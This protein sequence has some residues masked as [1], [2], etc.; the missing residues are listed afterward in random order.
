MATARAPRRVTPAAAGTRRAVLLFA[1]ALAGVVLL[2]RTGLPHSS[3]SG[4]G[5]RVLV[6]DD[7]TAAQLYS[8][9]RDAGSAADFAAKLRS[10]GL[11]A[12]GGGGPSGGA[13]T[14][15]SLDSSAGTD[16]AL[17]AA[18][19]KDPKQ[20]AGGKVPQLSKELAHGYARDGIIIVTWA[21]LH[22]LDFTLNWVHHM[23]VHGITNY[24]VGAMDKETGQALA[25][26]G[27]NVFAMYDTNAADTG[28][29]TADFGW[30]TA[31]FHKMGRQKVDLARTFTDFGLDLCL[32]DVDTVWINDPTEYFE[33][34][35]E[36]DI[37]A[38]S[39]DLDPSNQPGDDGLEQ[40]DAIHSAMNIGLLFFRHGR[41]TTLFIDAW[42]KQLDSDESAWDQNVFNWVAH[43]GLLPFQSPPENER[44]VWGTNHSLVFGVLPVAAF[45]S[46]HTFFVQRLF[47]LQKVKPYVVHCTFQYGGSAG[48]RHRLRE[49]MLWVDPP[50]YYGEGQ[51][52]SV[53]FTYP[54][55]PKDFQEQDKTMMEGKRFKTTW[56]HNKMVDFHIKAVASELKQLKTA[57]KLAVALNRTI[58]MPKLLSWCDRYWGPLEY[59]QIPGA[60]RTRLPFIAPMDHLIEPANLGEGKHN[61]PEHGPIITFREYSF[62]ENE[63]TLGS[64]KE[65]KL[66]VQSSTTAKEAQMGK[67]G[68]QKVLTIPAKPSDKQLRELLQPYEGNQLLHFSS[69]DGAFGKF[70]EQEDTQRFQARLAHMMGFHCCKQVKEGEDG[71]F[72]YYQLL[73]DPNE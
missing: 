63:R 26:R 32:C 41:N 70:E 4:G 1:L 7:A 13:S 47:E 45:A 50:K 60:F 64:L 39:D 15:S 44:L 8:L 22:F 23:E 56:D 10:A 9:A 34:F 12:G 55:T 11:M 33:R 21:N 67:E 58:I 52:L 57:L 29:G 65:S 37:L 68:G 42:Q 46:G 27:L 40:L 18:K 61:K 19:G 16:V 31:A 66:V 3:Q 43:E 48:K 20:K 72:G 49:A 51:F 62:L 73:E 6:E 5:G 38:S 53:D 30:G 54:E 71:G 35:P 59:C 14:D 36:A 17:P 24:L 28:L 2:G 69:L 25:E